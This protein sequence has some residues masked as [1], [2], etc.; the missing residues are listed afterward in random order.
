MG[1]W[2]VCVLTGSYDMDG[3]EVGIELFGKTREG[4]GCVVR[5]LGF[6]PY[7][8]IA[9]PTP[10]ITRELE[11]DNMNYAALEVAKREGAAAFGFKYDDMPRPDSLHLTIE[12]VY[13]KH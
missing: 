2:D 11:A 4:G 7:F 6:K 10:E 9:Q 8:Y 13:V 12:P 1:T 5:Y 3:D